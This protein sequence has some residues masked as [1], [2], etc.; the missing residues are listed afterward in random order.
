MIKIPILGVKPINIFLLGSI[1]LLVVLIPP[2][3]IYAQNS[4]I[5]LNN[6]LSLNSNTTKSEQLE[7]MGL[8]S[9]YQQLE[10]EITKIMNIAHQS[11][12]LTNTF[13]SFPVVNLTT[14]M[15]QQ[16]RGIPSDQDVEKR[17]EAKKLLTD[18]PSLL[19]VGMNFPNGDTYFSEPYFPS[20]ANS[21]VS[22][23][24][25]RDHII[26]AQETK[27]PYLSNVITAA[28]TGKPIAV[29]ATPIFSD[30][31]ADSTLV[32][33]LAFGLNFTHFN[34]LLKSKSDNNSTRLLLLD[35]NGT[36]ISDYDSTSNSNLSESFAVLQSFK[37][38]KEGELGS[39]MENIDGKNMTISYVPINFAQT[40]WILLS[41]APNN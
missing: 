23:Y 21:S 26:G 20:Q 18:N 38:A 6:D 19:F 15:Q 34:E 40:K 27:Q 4:D 3:S 25:Y 7:I 33:M 22:N 12:N 16:Y 13:G 2:M 11:M 36:E 37:N 14:D 30:K 8:Y 32:G 1:V 31:T 28:S 9:V 17:N 41:M 24:G 35:N 29:L 10:M 39:I 5:Q